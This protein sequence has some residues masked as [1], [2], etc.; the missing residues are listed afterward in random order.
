MKNAFPNIKKEKES[1]NILPNFTLS[2]EQITKTSFTKWFNDKTILWVNQADL[3]LAKF[4]QIEEKQNSNDTFLKSK[5]IL[6]K[7]NA[8]EGGFGVRCF[9]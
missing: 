9:K 6:Q 2:Q 3:C 5:E 4:M 1:F 8:I 7:L